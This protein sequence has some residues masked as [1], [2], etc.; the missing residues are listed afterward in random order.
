ML[1]LAICFSV[2]LTCQHDTGLPVKLID[3][4]LDD[5]FVELA[6]SEEVVATGGLHVNKAVA[7]D[8]DGHV[9]GASAQVEHQHLLFIVIVI[10][11]LLGLRYVQTIC[12]CR[13]RGLVDNAEAIQPC[14]TTGVL[15][16]GFL[17]TAEV[18]RNCDDSMRHLLAQITLSDRFHFLQ[19]H[20]C[21]LL[22][23]VM[24]GVRHAILDNRNRYHRSIR[25]HFADD[26]EGPTL[27]TPLN[28]LV[29]KGSTQNSFDVI[30]DVVIS[31]LA[32]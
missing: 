11:I 2:L 7:H 21:K 30:D 27:A 25:V 12:D 26:T 31:L 5:S 24:L 16:R 10:V 20:G 13:C 28:L 19:S 3:T 4:Q 18:G 8:E 29:G 9:K 17:S 15:C 1:K 14:D 22:W 23:I 32:L 6:A